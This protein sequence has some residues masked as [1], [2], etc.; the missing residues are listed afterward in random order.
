MREKPDVPGKGELAVKLI[1]F[2]FVQAVF[3]LSGG[4]FFQSR[5]NL[6]AWLYFDLFFF[7]VFFLRFI[8]PDVIPRYAGAFLGVFVAMCV[9]LLPIEIDDDW[10]LVIAVMPAVVGQL[11]WILYNRLPAVQRANAR[12][13]EAKKE[14]EAALAGVS[15]AKHPAG[16][17]TAAEAEYAGDGARDPPIDVAGLAHEIDEIRNR[18]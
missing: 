2:A 10:A 18:K 15:A 6:L 7:Y 13:Q 11:A 5:Q 3:F 1:V 16:T 4:G 9:L 12:R 14:G 8:R 17:G